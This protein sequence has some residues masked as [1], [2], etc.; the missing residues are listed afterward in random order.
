MFAL[1]VDN[2]D[3]APSSRQSI[4]Y[5]K[6]KYAA[7]E[8]AFLSQAEMLNGEIKSLRE[9]LHQQ[10]KAYEITTQRKL[11]ELQRQHQADLDE[12][13]LSIQSKNRG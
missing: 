4:E 9:Q 8:A 5:L 11:E 1:K 3:E 12:L 2:Q 13:R 6:Q 10:H 7:S